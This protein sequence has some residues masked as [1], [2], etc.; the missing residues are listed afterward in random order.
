ME[1]V[2]R[3]LLAS[4]TQ[5]ERVDLLDNTGELQK[6]L[7]VGITKAGATPLGWQLHHFEPQGCTLLGLLAESHVSIH[8]YPEQRSLFLDAFT[9]GTTCEPLAIFDAVRECI[10]PCQFVHEVLLR[11]DRASTRYETFSNTVTS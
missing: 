5:I 10:G 8:T 2:G 9:C 7:L 3:H 1:F 4:F 6:A 11:S